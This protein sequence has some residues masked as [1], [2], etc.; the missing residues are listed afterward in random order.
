MFTEVDDGKGV[1]EIRREGIKNS[2]LDILSL[3]CLSDIHPRENVKSWIG[4][5]FEDPRKSDN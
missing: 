3:Q 5:R 4:Y 2:I 1:K